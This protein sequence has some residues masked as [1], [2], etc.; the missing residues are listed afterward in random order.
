MQIHGSSLPA[1]ESP[2]HA[3]RVGLA[4]RVLGDYH[5]TGLFWYRFHRWAMASMPDWTKSAIV[6]VFTTLFFPTIRN[7]RRAIAANLE[8]VLGPCGF[9]ERQQR[10]FRT[11]YVFG[12]C[13]S[14]RY[15]RLVTDASFEVAV[16]AIEHWREVAASGRGVVMVTAHLGMYEAGSMLPASIDKRHVHLVREPEV[17]PR[18]QE[19]IRES[20]RSV[21][22]SH[23]TMHFQ[24]DDP[25]QGMAL[26]DAL[27]RGEIVA[28][29]GDRPRAGSRTVQGTLFGRPLAL[30]SGPAIL[31]RTA[32]APM[33]PVFAIRE[34]RRRYRI[35]FGPPIDVP[36]TGDRTADAAAA[37]GRV[38]AEV[39]R[40]VR[41]A[42][43]QWFVFRE[44]WPGA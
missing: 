32:G 13:L 8:A 37:M 40:A 14:E 38:A 9:F 10:I 29:Q 15:E 16:E 31:A 43:H 30:P 7:I 3:P 12:W 36:E 42:P 34:G 18:A 21:E 19:F 2:P 4:R 5:V 22:G 27:R 41:R 28:M 33:L 17:D 6:V 44:L 35:V 1:V 20:V 11:M 24:T 25:L 23:Y 26:L 39:E